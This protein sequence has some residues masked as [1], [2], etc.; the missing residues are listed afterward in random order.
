MSP[1]SNMVPKR[2]LSSIPEENEGE[3]TDGIE[4]L[5]RKYRKVLN[6]IP[7]EGIDVGDSQEVLDP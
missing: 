3:N 2:V 1:I 4:L 6:P 5:R 7:I